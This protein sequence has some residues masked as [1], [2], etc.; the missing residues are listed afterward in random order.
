MV[1]F[2]K[3]LWAFDIFVGGE[4]AITKLPFNKGSSEYPSSFIIP[5]SS[6]L[7]SLLYANSA[8]SRLSS[9][10]SAHAFAAPKR[11]NPLIN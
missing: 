5:H 4:L 6:H 2:V 7:M 8:P 11:Q 9:L 3:S 1:H 10:L